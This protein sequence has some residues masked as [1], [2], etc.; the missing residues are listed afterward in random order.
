MEADFTNTGLNA[1]DGVLI[2]ADLEFNASL[3][4]L[5]M[6]YNAIS[7]DLAQQLAASVLTSK[8]LEVFSKVPIK[9]LRADKL[10]E[11]SLYSNGLGPTEGIVIAELLKVTDSLTTL[12]LADNQICGLNY[13]GEGTYTAVGIN[14]ICDAL[15]VNA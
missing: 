4:N 5:D 11:L 2:A 6:R 10:T 7:G 3:T 8:S 9:E 1:A 13:M 14:A 15:G 12:N